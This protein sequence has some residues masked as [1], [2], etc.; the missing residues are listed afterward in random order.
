MVTGGAHVLLGVAG[1]NFARFSLAH[2]RRRDRLRHLRTS[3]CRIVLPSVVWLALVVAL[4]DSYGLTNVFLM[5]TMLGPDGW[6]DAWHY[7]Y[8]E[9]L[10][11][12]L[13]A[14]A[15]LVAIPQVHRWERASPFWFVAAP[16]IGALVL[17]FELL[18]PGSSPDRM[19][20]PQYV[21]WVFALGWAAAQASTRK[22]RLVV[23][24]VALVA[25]PGF[26]GDPSRDAVVVVG[27]L[28]LVW[29]GSVTVP[30]ALAGPLALLASASLFIYLT[31][32][33]VY[34]H[35]EF[36]WPLGALLASLVVGVCAWALAHRIGLCAAVLRGRRLAWPGDLARERQRSQLATRLAV[37]PLRGPAADPSRRT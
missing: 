35:L 8:V 29:R 6:T 1:F 21:F 7:W 3:I 10:V 11:L 36:R 24:A 28:L 25:T 37:R 31:H 33:Q 9:S 4:T 17:R 18:T 16:V 14:L 23:S 2:P 34:P 22:H 30:S 27:L 15:A 19:H 13:V 5:N 32:W 26:F 20:S 12:M